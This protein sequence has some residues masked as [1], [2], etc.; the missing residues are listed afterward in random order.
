M[1]HRKRKLQ[2][3]ATQLNPLSYGKDAIDRLT[4]FA[5]HLE[6]RMREAN[7]LGLPKVRLEMIEQQTAQILLML[8]RRVIK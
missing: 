6:L 8:V 2:E 3:D 1:A 7:R 5:L 4:E